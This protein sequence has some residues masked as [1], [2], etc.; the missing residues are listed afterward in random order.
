MAYNTQAQVRIISIENVLDKLGCWKVLPRRRVHVKQ[1]SI[2][3][4][5]QRKLRYHQIRTHKL[6]YNLN[7]LQ[8]N[9]SSSDQ[10]L[11][12][13]LDPFNIYSQFHPIVAQFKTNRWES[14]IRTIGCN[15][16]CLSSRHIM[17]YLDCKYK[18]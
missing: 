7:T 6:C 11:M 13:S 10:V 5:L 12:I 3:L 2:P 9:I 14:N 8:R 16:L 15:G 1:L 18:G 17:A 4:L